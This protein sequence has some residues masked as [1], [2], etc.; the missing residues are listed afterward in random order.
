MT[1]HLWKRPAA[2]WVAAGAGFFL[3][4]SDFARGS[5]DGGI[6]NADASFLSDA[7]D[8]EVGPPPSCGCTLPPCLPI[9][10]YEDPF[11]APTFGLLLDATD[12]YY[13]GAGFIERIGKD[14]TGLRRVYFDPSRLP[15]VVQGAD[16]TSI[17]FTIASADFSSFRVA[18]VGKDGTGYAELATASGPGVKVALGAGD[19]FV[20]VNGNA[21]IVDA[22]VDASPDADLDAIF[23]V[24]T[25]GTGR[26]TIAQASAVA[27]ATAGPYLFYSFARS[28]VEPGLVRTGLDGTNGITIAAETAE[29][30]V[31]DP[32]SVY[33]LRAE[34][35]RSIRRAAADGTGGSTVYESPEAG[36]RLDLLAIE[37]ASLYFVSGATIMKVGTAPASGPPAPLFEESAS[38]IE[39]LAVDECSVFWKTADHRLRKLPK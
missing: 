25:D 1:D 16:A 22:G 14:G 8:E 31:L 11:G 12:A 19:L 17:Y 2:C 29:R 23:G 39:A 3:A 20:G 26:V 32:T 28:D 15:M 21:P 10:L 6:D 4:C 24:K 13:G 37:S 34:L 30:I 38:V 36:T 33:W 27:L 9:D 7:L 5:I 18:K 35:P